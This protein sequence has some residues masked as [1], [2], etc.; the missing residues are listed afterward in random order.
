MA[1]EGVEKYM[2]KRNIPLGYIILAVL[3][4][5]VILVSIGFPS[6]FD[7]KMIGKAKVSNINADD[8]PGFMGSYAGGILGGILGS[9]AT[10]LGVY[11]SIRQQQKQVREERRLSVRPALYCLRLKEDEVDNLSSWSVEKINIARTK[12]TKTEECIL[13]FRT[14]NLGPGNIIKIMLHIPEIDLEDNA[15]GPEDGLTKSGE[16]RYWKKTFVVTY[17]AHE[18]RFYYPLTLVLYYTDVFGNVYTQTA[19]AY[20]QKVE[21]EEDGVRAE[22]PVSAELRGECTKPE[23]AKKIPWYMGTWQG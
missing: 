9:V 12:N 23:L 1:V 3:L 14:D 18:E 21:A 5:A 10:I 22:S 16:C 8:W 20:I 13:C 2:Q 19:Y 17:D 7:L 11:I 4:I 15:S 6:F